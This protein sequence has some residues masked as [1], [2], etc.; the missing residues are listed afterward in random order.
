[1][2]SSE[3][4]GLSG[5]L[6][7]QRLI[8]LA[9][10]NVANANTPGYHRQVAT[11]APKVIGQ[12]AGLG[13]EITQLRRVLDRNVESA[14]TR[15][16]FSLADATAQ[17]DLMR[18]VELQVNPGDGSVHDLLEQ[19][20]NQLEQL[21]GRPDDMTQRRV[22]LG[23]AEALCE[24]LNNLNFG[25]AE[26]RRGI[27]QQVI[28]RVEQ[29]NQLAREI[30]EFNTTIQRNT[31]QGGNANELSDRRDVLINQLAELIDVRVVEQD[32]GVVNVIAGGL[33]LVL[34]TQSIELQAVID[35]ADQMKVTARGVPGRVTLAGGI[36]GGLLAVR[37]QTAPNFMQRMEDFTRTLVQSLDKVHAMG[38]GLSGPF[39]Q[40]NGI[41]AVSQTDVPLGQAG[42]TFPPQAGSL[43]ISVTNLA[44]GA[45]VLHEIAVDPQ[46]QS[47]D[48]LATA[49]SSAAN[50]QAVVDAQTNTLTLIAAPGFAFDFAG[51]LPSAPENVAISGTAVPRIGG[52]YTGSDNDEF[53]FSV[54]GTG[55]VGVTPGLTLEAR[56]S[57]GQLVSSWNV[58]QGYEPGSP[59]PALD[60]VQVRLEAGTVNSGDSFT[61]KVVAD[62][63][64]A[65]LL[66]SLGLNTF[67]E[68]GVSDLHVRGD[69]L[70]NP[71]RL[72]SSQSG[73]PADGTALHRLAALRD[74]AVMS[75][76]AATLREF[77]AE[78]AAEA[79]GRVQ[80]LDDR[81][82][83]GELLGRNLEA[84]RQSISGVDP[85][86]E[87]MRLV[88][89]Q[90]S[91]QLSA[92]FLAVVDETL[93]DLLRLV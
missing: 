34:A 68:G 13:V 51:R 18:Q 26:I 9:G 8:D 3:S 48:D 1:M 2:A 63:D 11:L 32:Y 39:R 59:L 72:S 49:I 76:G 37:N 29:A 88:E 38:L 6:T 14:L 44:S 83:A 86:E 67:F 10:Q 46:T 89:F 12:Q 24:R 5:L 69:L 80:A 79:G 75:G 77:Y 90:R 65:D 17:L 85:N 15:N 40:L 91:F 25:L 84:Q 21:A 73:L 35:D 55:T 70:T 81:Q 7:S 33:P 61:C 20:F 36:L 57:A 23:T 28:E 50:V 74:E 66:T 62:A 92:R 45:R 41:R 27:D 64:S 52:T 87:L 71:E 93:A 31:I 16:I 56:N 54:V 58:G 43:Y 42:L 82:S 4:I 53:T 30:A 78:L 19:F 47:L 60:G 22:V